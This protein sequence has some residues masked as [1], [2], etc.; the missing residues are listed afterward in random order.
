MRL[1]R[2]DFKTAAMTNFKRYAVYY[3]PELGP[4]MDFGSAWLGWDPVK[5]ALAAPR[6]VKGLPLPLDVITQTPRKYGF[7]G[8]IKPPFRLAEGMGQDDLVAAFNALALG[9]PAIQLEGL[10]LS[11]LGRFLALTPQGDTTELE[12]LAAAFVR[13]LDAFRAP[14]TDADIVRRN[15][16]RLSAQQR[17]LLLQWGYPYVMEEFRFH[18]TLS[19]RLGPDD[20]DQTEAALTPLVTPLLPRPFTIDS[21]CLFGEDEDGMFHLFHRARLSG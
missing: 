1:L 11:R 9:I 8:T 6:P 20:L 13:G 5:G 16:N 19:G 7:H 15:P 2:F 3:A 10:A 21:M 12:E 17:S 18:M 4:L 14:L